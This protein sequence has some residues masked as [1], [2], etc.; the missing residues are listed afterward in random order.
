MRTNLL[1]T[2]GAKKAESI[3]K[4]DVVATIHKIM[5]RGARYQANRNLA[6]LRTIFNWAI[7]HDLVETNPALRIPRPAEEIERA[8]VLAEPEDPAVLRH[9]W[10]GADDA[11]GPDCP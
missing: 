10:F 4:S 6:L 5:D 2:L 1:P 3:T 9:D 8:R 7:D 11:S